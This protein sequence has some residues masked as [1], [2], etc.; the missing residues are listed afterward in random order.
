ME[1]FWYMGL[2]YNKYYKH[3]IPFFSFAILLQK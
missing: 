1:L 2:T 3:N